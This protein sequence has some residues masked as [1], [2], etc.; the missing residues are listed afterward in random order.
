[1][2]PMSLRCRGMFSSFSSYQFASACLFWTR[3]SDRSRA[4]AFRESNGFLL[5]FRKSGI[6]TFL[7]YL[8]HLMGFLFSNFKVTINISIRSP[9]GKPIFWFSLFGFIFSYAFRFLSRLFTSDLLFFDRYR[10]MLS[11][12]S[13]LIVKKWDS[14]VSN[15]FCMVH[16]EM[17]LV[18]MGERSIMIFRWRF[19]L[20]YTERRNRPNQSCQKAWSAGLN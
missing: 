4:C 19:Y 3:T 12:L 10:A 16:Y 11:A 13:P 2:Q 6:P 17:G 18:E 9:H 14:F 15:G 7:I 5:T 1:M 20:Y 8:P